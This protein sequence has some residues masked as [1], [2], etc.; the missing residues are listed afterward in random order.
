[1][2]D[3]TLDASPQR[4]LPRVDRLSFGWALKRAV[5]GL[6]IMLAVTTLAAYLANASIE[7]SGDVAQTKAITIGAPAAALLIRR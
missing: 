5:L 6:A 2:S 3:V 4:V 1:M 7:P